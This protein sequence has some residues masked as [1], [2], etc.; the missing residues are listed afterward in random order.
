[1]TGLRAIL[2]ILLIVPIAEGDFLTA[3]VLYTVASITDFL[4]GFLAR[5]LNQRSKLGQILDPLADKLLIFTTYFG[6]L[7]S[8][9]YFK[10]GTFL[11]L[12]VVV[13][14]I[15]I[16]LGSLYLLK[17]GFLPKPTI[18]GK[19]SVALLMFYGGILLLFNGFQ[20]KTGKVICEGL[21]YITLFAIWAAVLS[22]LLEFWKLLSKENRTQPL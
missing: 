14:E 12:S 5:K 10:P 2:S 8:K 18:A 7:F 17:K 3:L 16:L 19:I 11:I 21:D 22:Y 1:M 4:D 9:T 13:K 6:L 20:I 15:L